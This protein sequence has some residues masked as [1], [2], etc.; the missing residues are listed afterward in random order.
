MIFTAEYP[1][2]RTLAQA[3]LIVAER[4]IAVLRVPTVV[5]MCLGGIAVLEVCINVDSHSFSLRVVHGQ[6]YS[7]PPYSVRCK[8]L[9]LSKLNDANVS[10]LFT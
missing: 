1:W 4:T 2:L 9:R 7:S 8:L 3:E 10:F 5:V 6:E